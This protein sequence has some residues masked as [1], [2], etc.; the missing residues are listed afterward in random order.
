MTERYKQPFVGE[1]KMLFVNRSKLP[2]VAHHTLQSEDRPWAATKS[3]ICASIRGTCLAVSSGSPAAFSTTQGTKR[4]MM[5]EMVRPFPPPPSPSILDQP[6]VQATRI[7]VAEGA[8]AS[9]PPP[10]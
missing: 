7:V 8:E 1:K 6:V 9:P 5:F 2:K 10:R 3:S 4:R